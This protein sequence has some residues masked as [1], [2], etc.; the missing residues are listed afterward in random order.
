MDNFVSVTVAQHGDAQRAIN[1]AVRL[2]YDFVTYFE[3]EAND[4]LA[5]IHTTRGDMKYAKSFI[6]ALRYNCTGNLSWRY[7]IICTQQI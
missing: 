2:L 4:F 6:Y 3:N 7:V 5:K 1:D